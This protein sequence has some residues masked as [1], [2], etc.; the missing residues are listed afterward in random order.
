MRRSD[1]GVCPALDVSLDRAR[2]VSKMGRTRLEPNGRRTTTVSIWRRF[3]YHVTKVLLCSA[4]A[5][6][7]CRELPFEHV[8]A[9][10]EPLFALVGP[11]AAID[12]GTS[13]A[14]AIA[15][16]GKVACWGWNLIGQASVPVSLGIVTAVTAGGVHT[17]ALK[18][19]GSVTCWGE[20]SN[21]ETSVPATLGTASQLSAGHAHTCAVKGDGA[22]VCWGF[23][24]FGQTN[25][26]TT[27][28]L[29]SRVSAGGNLTCAIK[30]NGQVQCWGRNDIG[31]AN[32]PASL[33]SVTE[34]SVGADHSCALK[35]DGGVAC[36][37]SNAVGQTNVPA[38][39]AATQVS[40]GGNHS[41]AL[42]TD[43]S[44][45]CWGFASF[46]Q[47]SVP[48]GLANVAQVNAGGNHTC[49]LKSDGSISCWGNPTGGLL[50]GSFS[51]VS[52]GWLAHACAHRSD[53]TVSCWGDRLGG[54]PMPASLGSPTKISVGGVHACALKSD[55]SV[56]CWGSN[57]AG[58]APPAAL[59]AAT[60]ISAGTQHTCAVSSD[61]RVSCWGFNDRGQSTV[62][63]DLGTATQVSAGQF[64]T[65]ALKSDGTVSCWGFNLSGQ[66]NV[67]ATLT[68]V[69]QV[70]AG[71]VH[72]CALKNDA[73]IVCWGFNGAGA[74]TV[75]TGLGPAMQVSLG[76]GH[77]CALTINGG[78]VCWGSNSRGQRNVPTDLGT[79][80]RISAAGEQTCAVKTDNT[81][82][83]WGSL[84]STAY[85]PPPP[86]PPV[87]F[88]Q[89]PR[90]NSEA[91]ALRSNVDVGTGSFESTQQVA[92]GFTLATRSQLTY[93]SWE[94]TYF[95]TTVSIPSVAFRIQIYSN[96]SQAPIY[97]AVVNANH[98]R[99]GTSEF[100]SPILRFSANLSG[101]V[102]EAGRPYWIAIL[103]SDANTSIDFRWWKTATEGA[104]DFVVRSNA[105]S[106]WNIMNSDF[107]H[108][109]VF[110]LAGSAVASPGST[111]PGS[112]VNVQPVDE[113]TGEDAPV[114]LTFDNITSGGETT[115][116][117]GT[118][119]QGG[120]PSPGGF[121]LGNPPTYYDVQTSA[122]FTG[123]VE[124]CFDYSGASYGNENNLKL[125]HYENSVW[126]DVTTSRDTDNNIICGTVTSLSPFLVAEENGAPVVTSLVVPAAPV[127]IGTNVTTTAAFT[128][129]NPNDTHTATID[130]NDGATSNG[131]VTE[132][133]GIGSA[134]ASHA[135]TAPGVYTV[136][137]SVSDGD[138]N[139]TRSSSSDQPAYIVV[140]D[141]SSGFVTGGGWFD[142]PTNACVWSGCASDGSTTGKA[143]FGFVSRYRTG[144]TTPT[145]NTEFQ[146]KAGG[147]T[148]SSTSYQWLVV[149]GARAQYKGV[150]QIAGDAATYGFLI[151]AIDGALSGGGG[152]DRFR[153]KLWNV[154]T[155]AIVYDNQ[156]GQLDDSDA[157]TSIGGGSIV[158]H[159]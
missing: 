129:A 10:N 131:V 82:E 24:Q 38:A 34:V 101:P 133:G 117:S 114:E 90:G 26:P 151:T 31:Q 95:R 105:S 76:V 158:I 120:P 60:D 148:F 54:T 69:S 107:F 35:T 127:P 67:P 93:V 111:Q 80:T 28:G 152:T 68:G 56:A 132:S 150:G 16:D 123:S 22:A 109:F 126:T 145:G 103:D 40:V 20:N 58:L 36:W 61:G 147:L 78:V 137:A 149:A 94:G 42:R 125:L 134:N 155:G 30:T 85:L 29:V 37:G 46:G 19:D 124:L 146:F 25:V 7:G 102:L 110:E 92:D 39:L 23:N 141:P 50:D 106:P 99:V 43:G 45:V 138:L 128:D 113:A 116:S 9:P 81:I 130:W 74:T 89:G 15:S 12:V 41:C 13:H 97:D 157:A 21:G 73:S 144:A 77:T 49:A 159:K 52:A 55:A 4:A 48:P 98:L 14:C 112:D 53:G 47:T 2:G 119:G 1:E 108:D 115:V 63:P 8:P 139:G 104:G 142:S 118:V 33:G 11:A 122:T 84:T 136:S 153:I 17:C 32:V 51:N 44:V 65:C 71:G 75:P 143:S 91:D 86:P 72:S 3:G 121:R 83:C 59:G 6:A 27:L 57:S 64:H 100:G 5:S 87:F 96:L 70:S 79:A 66:T 140:Y 62:P 135:Y 156:I 88:S 18:I 154:A